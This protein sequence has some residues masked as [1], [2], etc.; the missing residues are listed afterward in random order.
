[1]TTITIQIPQEET[2]LFKAILKKFNATVVNEETDEFV[3]KIKKG[4][5]SYKNGNYITIKNPDN[6]WE[7][8]LS[9]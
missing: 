8:I 2:K 7:S 4:K 5:E 9:E 3:Q 1:M 6:I